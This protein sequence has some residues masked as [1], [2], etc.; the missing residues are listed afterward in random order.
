MDVTLYGQEIHEFID[1][2]MLD[3]MNEPDWEH[4]RINRWRPRMEFIT[5]RAMVLDDS[6][7]YNAYSHHA[8]SIYMRVTTT[9]HHTIG[10]LI[11]RG[12]LPK[13]MIEYY[14]GFQ[15]DAPIEERYLSPW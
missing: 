12:Y 9:N 8:N 3:N 6:G 10:W 7:H 13:W 1:A 14:G 2:M 5:A 11:E 15:N 4:F